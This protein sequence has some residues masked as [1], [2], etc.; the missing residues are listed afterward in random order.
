MGQSMPDL[1]Q[2]I[3]A[4]TLTMDE[5]ARNKAM[6]AVMGELVRRQ[7]YVPLDTLL[8]IAAARKPVS[9]TPQASEELILSAV[10]GP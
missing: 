8:V 4:A 5:A 6:A 1:D 10:Q 2:A 9:Y 3:D 7:A